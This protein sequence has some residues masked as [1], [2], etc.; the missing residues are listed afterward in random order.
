MLQAAGS[1][2]A[3]EAFPGRQTRAS[4]FHPESA[5]PTIRDGEVAADIDVAGVGFTNNP[6]P[7]S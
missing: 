6:S 1:A 4:G 2:G 5:E 7:S 3:G